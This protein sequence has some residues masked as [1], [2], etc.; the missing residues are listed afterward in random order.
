[1]KVERDWDDGRLEYEIEFWVDSTE[2]DYTVDGTSG[3]ILKRDTERHGSTSTG[4]TGNSGSTSSD[5]GSDKA[6]SIA[7]N[8]A[9][10]S[11]SSTYELKVKQDYDDGRL[12]YEVEFKANGVEYEYTILASD[13]SILS[14]ESDRDD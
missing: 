11:E 8:H 7:L 12:E 2:Y 4:S 6:K 5:I 14:H 1:M 9:G 10:V 13:G 3:A